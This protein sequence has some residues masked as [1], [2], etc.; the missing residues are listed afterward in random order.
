MTTAH[1]ALAGGYSLSV[2]YPLSSYII[3]VKSLLRNH[4]SNPYLHIKKPYAIPLVGLNADWI[5]KN[6]L[7]L[8]DVISP[9]NC[10]F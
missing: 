7:M 6:F 9:T 3:M 1:P 2:E 10:P 4:S 8:S 5:I